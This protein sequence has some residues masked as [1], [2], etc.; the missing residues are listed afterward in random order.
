MEDMAILL[1]YHG[2]ESDSDDWWDMYMY[3]RSAL[4][5]GQKKLSGKGVSPSVAILKW[6]RETSFESVMSGGVARPGW[7]TRTRPRTS[8]Y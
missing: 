4:M 5:V 1:S 7:G 3:R 8:V 2:G 6:T